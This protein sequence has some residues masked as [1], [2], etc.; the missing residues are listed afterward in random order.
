MVRRTPWI[1]AGQYTRFCDTRTCRLTTLWPVFAGKTPLAGKPGAR[2]R[3]TGLPGVDAMT[4]GHSPAAVNRLHHGASLRI[5]KMQCEGPAIRLYSRSKEPVAMNDTRIN[6]HDWPAFC[7][8]FTRLHRGWLTGIR[9]LDTRV[10]DEHPLPE[11][12]DTVPLV[13]EML[14]LQELREGHTDDRAEFLVTIGEGMDETTILVEDVVA[15]YGRTRD[16]AP[17]GVRIDSGDGK[18]LLVEFRVA[19]DPAT[20]DDLADSER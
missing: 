1:F 4:G 19:A 5:V 16:G 11:E 2:C 12:A 18:T 13:S 15:L 20:L 9:Q 7:A 10:L 14:P 17:Q 3:H 8:R 6:E